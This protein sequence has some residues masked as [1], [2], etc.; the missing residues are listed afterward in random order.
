M[1]SSLYMACLMLQSSNHY[2]C[3]SNYSTHLHNC[4][5]HPSIFTKAPKSPFSLPFLATP[6][7]QNAWKVAFPCSGN[8]RVTLPYSLEEA[9]KPEAR[10]IHTIKTLLAKARS[11]KANG[12]ALPTWQESLNMD[13]VRLCLRSPAFES[14][15]SW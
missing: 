4:A 7:A 6:L 14:V 2:T 10:S 1:R 11:K 3:L 5:Q 8:E 9:N 15:L 12:Q 13:Y